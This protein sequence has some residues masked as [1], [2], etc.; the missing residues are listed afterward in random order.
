[1]SEDIIERELEDAREL[2]T[3]MTFST[4]KLDHMLS[5][6]KSPSCKFLKF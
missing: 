2:K 4:E 3:K 1:M 6:G 5:V